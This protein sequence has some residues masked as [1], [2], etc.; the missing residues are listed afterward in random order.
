MA[1]QSN[2]LTL[3]SLVANP[4]SGPDYSVFIATFFKF[5]ITRKM[6]SRAAS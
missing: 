3:G 4:K 6:S 5:F 1:C 2:A